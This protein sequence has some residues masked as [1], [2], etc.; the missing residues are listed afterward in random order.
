MRIRNYSAAFAAA[1][2]VL[3]EASVTAQKAGT[4]GGTATYLADSASPFGPP[5]AADDDAKIAMPDLAFKADVTTDANFDKY[6]A[7]RRANT[8]FKTAYADIAE[9][10][11]YARGLQSGIGYVATPYPYVGT[12]AGAVGG[13]IGNAM[14]V[15]I[16]GSAE[17]R[18]LRR[19]N[20]RTCMHFKGYNRYGLSKDVWDKFNF[21]EGIGSVTEKKRYMY[22]K[23]QAMVASSGNL[24]GKVLGL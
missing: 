15:L 14:A 5:P 2:L 8:D 4:V 13:A 7:F 3:G 6:Y 19:V 23:Q 21:E 1:T 18:R 24:Q 17:K 16:F 10:D 20:M 22:L 11:S 9:C 12:M